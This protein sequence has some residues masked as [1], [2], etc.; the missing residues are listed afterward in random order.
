VIRILSPDDKTSE[1]LQRF[2]AYKRIGVLHVIL[3]DLEEY[4]AFRFEDGSLLQSRFTTLDLPSGS[5][6][7]DSEARFRQLMDERAEG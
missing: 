4:L 5:V 3:L 2:Q 6:P 1:Q 7:F